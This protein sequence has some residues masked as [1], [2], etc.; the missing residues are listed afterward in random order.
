M[1]HENIAFVLPAGCWLGGNKSYGSNGCFKPL[2]RFEI[3]TEKKNLAFQGKELISS[4]I[5]TDNRILERV[6]KFTYL[7]YT[8]PP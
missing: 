1:R 6:N 8:L 5:C 7:G 3:S 2:D 4:K